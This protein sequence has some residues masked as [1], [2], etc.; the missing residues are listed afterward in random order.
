MK[1]YVGRPLKYK[2]LIYDLEDDVIYSPAKIA[3]HAQ[4]SGYILSRDKSVI[5]LHKQRIRIALARISSYRRFPDNGDGFVTA[6]GQAVTVGW[7]GWRWKHAMVDL[8]KEI[9]QDI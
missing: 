3:N 4:E 1:D 5:R 2:E 9:E 6:P 7:F 8:N